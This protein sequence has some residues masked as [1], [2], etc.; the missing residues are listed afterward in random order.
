MSRSY[1]SQIRILLIQ[2]NNDK[3]ELAKAYQ[4]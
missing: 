2:I 3:A 1:I 4:D